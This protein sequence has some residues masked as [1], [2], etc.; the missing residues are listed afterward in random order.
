MSRLSKV[1]PYIKDPIGIN[2]VKNSK[3][4]KDTFVYEGDQGSTLDSS[5]YRIIRN[6]I[7]MYRI[8]QIQTTRSAICNHV[9][10]IL[11]KCIIHLDSIYYKLIGPGIE[12][13]LINSEMNKV[14]TERVREGVFINSSLQ[15][16]R[17]F[18]SSFFNE[19]FNETG[20][21]VYPKF[22]DECL[23]IQCNTN[24]E[25]CFG[26]KQSNYKV[27][28]KDF[29]I[30]CIKDK[31]CN[32][33]RDS[34]IFRC[35]KFKDMTFCI[36]NVI[37]LSENVNNPPPIPYIDISELKSELNRLE[38][39]HTLIDT[40]FELKTEVDGIESTNRYTVS[41]SSKSHTVNANYIDM[42][43]KHPCLRLDLPDGEYKFITGMMPAEL[44]K[45]IRP[46]VEKLLSTSNKELHTQIQY[47][48]QL[49]NDMDNINSLSLIGTLE[50][51]DN[52]SK[53]ASNKITCNYKFSQD[54]VKKLYE[55]LDT[56]STIQQK[57]DYEYLE[58][59][60]NTIKKFIIDAY[61]KNIMSR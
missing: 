56:N 54:D 16:M 47:L 60:R 57:I 43:K 30:E 53:Y 3:N 9:I 58:K 6:F 17:K 32:Q 7:Y 31:L 29:I 14:C 23:P 12:R 2:D 24:T 42:F 36:F 13:D 37:N 8:P 44:R 61:D 5:S 15:D 35:N 52:M 1:T 39:I 41:D 11:D 38:S 46:I 21:R 51:T 27:N 4:K 49:I 25:D 40:K 20:K 18:I 59:Y 55:P 34:G 10:S 19:K 22:I 26:S 45:S 50:F 28:R 33:E 48:S